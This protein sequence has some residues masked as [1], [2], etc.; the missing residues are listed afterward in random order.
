MNKKNTIKYLEHIIGSLTSKNPT[1]PVTIVSFIKELTGENSVEYSEL[2]KTYKS[3]FIKDKNTLVLH[4]LKDLLFRIKLYGKPIIKR[5]NFLYHIK[6]SYVIALIS[7]LCL[8]C[9]LI[10]QFTTNE[11]KLYVENKSLNEQ[12]NKLKLNTDSMSQKLINISKRTHNKDTIT[13]KK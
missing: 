6:D 13:N 2:I 5:N 11:N 12:I 1:S 4:I 7:G 10:G 3:D 8:G 9:F